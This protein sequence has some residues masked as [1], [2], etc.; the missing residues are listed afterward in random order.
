LGGPEAL[1][2]ETPEWML[3]DLA[4]TKYFSSIIVGDKDYFRNPIY[5]VKD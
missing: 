3:E 2:N 1:K 5:Y 4:K